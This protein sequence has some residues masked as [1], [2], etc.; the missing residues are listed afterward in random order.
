MAC[1]VDHRR[2]YN[3]SDRDEHVIRPLDKGA[4]TA[5]VLAHKHM[6]DSARDCDSRC[7]FP[8]RRPTGARPLRIRLHDFVSL[9][10][11]S[12]IQRTSRRIAR[13][14]TWLTCP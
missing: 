4:Q 11:P 12:S 2:T 14:K 8:E 5:G 13:M 7:L 6:A 1:T 9:E 3:P 10:A